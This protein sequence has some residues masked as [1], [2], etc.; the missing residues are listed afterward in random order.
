MVDLLTKY[1]K[2]VPRYTSYPTAPQFS[3]DIGATH[4]QKWLG[5]L[6]ENEAISIY[7]HVPYC[8]KLCYF[9]GCNMKVVNGDSAIESYAETLMLDIAN[10][11]KAIGRRQKVAHVHWGGGTPSV[12]PPAYFA[13][14]VACLNAHFEILPTAEQAIELDPRV[15]TEDIVEAYAATGLNRSS[16]GVQD[17]DATVQQA[18]NRVQ[19]YDMTLNTV[20]WLRQYGMGAVNFDLIYGLPEQTLDTMKYSV[21]CTL[22]MRPNRVALFGYAHVPWMKKHQKL[23]EKYRLPTPE[24]RQEMFEEATT[25]LVAA[26]YVKI[27][28]DH[29]AVPEDSMAIAHASQN[30]HRN[31]QGFTTD[32][33]EFLVNLGATSIG[34]LP[35]GYVQNH[36]DVADWRAAVEAGIAATAKGVGIS[37]QD[38]LR[39]QMIERLMCDYAVDVKAVCA[40]MNM[41]QEMVAD[42]WPKLTELEADGVVE[43][44]DDKIRVTEAGMPLVRVVASCFDTYFTA[45]KNKHAQAV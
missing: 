31:F 26:G 45:E 44:S 19:P 2:P 1:N 39:R 40:R 23:L 28:Y 7:L 36:M 4:T 6:D 14:L 43:I 8:R 20:N 24:Q 11:A 15:L 10:T 22:E 25:M 13:R 27:G 34:T 33:A 21:D 30:L 29:F 32:P 38:R 3:A 41:P 9:C 16:I 35:G 37:A 18:I 17:F 12:T 5:E 42:V